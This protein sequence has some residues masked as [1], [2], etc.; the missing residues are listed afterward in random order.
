MNV[1]VFKGGCNKP[2]QGG[3]HTGTIWS[4]RHTVKPL[5]GIQ[6]VTDSWILLLIIQAE[7]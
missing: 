5:S 1:P 7:R 6:V 3:K 4:Y 2:S